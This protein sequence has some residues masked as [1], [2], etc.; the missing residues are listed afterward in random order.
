[1]ASTS[2]ILGARPNGVAPA[3]A[4]V[5]RIIE[6]NRLACEYQPIVE[7]ETG[8]IWA[9]EALSRFHIDGEL[10]AP[11]L[12]FEAL[13]TDQTLFFM[14]ESRAKRFQLQHRPEGRL[15]V[16]VD[17]SACLEDYQLEHWL[18]TLPNHPDVV[19]EIVE[20]TTVQRL[21]AVRAF[22]RQLA[23][24]GVRVALDDVGGRHSLFSFELLEHCHVVK[25]DRHW[26]S[27]VERDPAYE[28][29]VSGILAFT[30]DRGIH[31]VLEGVETE[32]DLEVARRLGVDL[33][34]GFLY[35]DEFI[36]VR[37][38]QRTFA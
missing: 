37:D 20:N 15:F 9:Y 7:I 25:L 14:L 4:D 17:P 1:M 22:T 13:Q 10:V 18:G 29:L 5:V 6:S 38:S 28:R 19:V 35:R 34:Q 33:V 8:E 12:V 3:K 21:D 31:A 30:R 16:N 11:N 26:L 36:T 23:D 24:A 27:R 32:A 2:P